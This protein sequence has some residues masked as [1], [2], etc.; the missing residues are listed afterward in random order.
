MVGGKLVNWQNQIIKI[1]DAF[2]AV[3]QKIIKPLLHLRAHFGSH[4]TQDTY[5]MALGLAALRPALGLPRKRGEELS[6]S[7]HMMIT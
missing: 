4:A 7:I 2:P 3:N 5:V 6:C 1:A